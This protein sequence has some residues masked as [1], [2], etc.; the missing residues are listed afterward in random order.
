M[1][2][3][4]RGSG[5]PIKAPVIDMIEIGAGGGSIAAHRRGRPAARSGPQSAGADP[6]PA[7]YGRGGKEPTVTD[8]NLLLGYYDPGLLPRR[9]HGA[10]R[11][12]RRAALAR[13]GRAARPV[14]SIE[15][16]WGIHTVVV[17]SMAAPRACIWSRRARIRARYAMV[18]F[19]GAGP[20]HA[21]DVARALGIARGHRSAGLG[22]RLGA[23]LPRR[24]AVVRASRALADRRLGDGFDCGARQRAARAQL[25]AKAARRSPR[26]ASPTPTVTVERIADMR[27]VGQMHEIAVPLPRRRARRRQPAERSARLRRRLPRALLRALL[28]GAR[29]EAINFRVRGRGAGAA[30]S[31]CPARSPAARR[32]GAAQGHRAAP[33]SSGGFARHARST[34]ATRLRPGDASPARRSS[35]S[36]RRRP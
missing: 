8:A 9:P 30:S 17:E 7:C 10:R 35:R 4:K 2:R 1:H 12:G 20:A 14:A 18:G 32:R 13:L 19:G 6:G 25:E 11:R 23:R 28:D 27:L 24:A 29:I 26:P 15:A 21:A 16:A 3:F 22:R 33:G 36:A 31:R 34:T 5:L